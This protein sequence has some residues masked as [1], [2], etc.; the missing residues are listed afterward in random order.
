M[1]AVPVAIDKYVGIVDA[2]PYEGQIDPWTVLTREGDVTGTLEVRGLPFDA[3]P[4]RSLDAKNSVWATTLGEL[5]RS[6]KL[7]LWAHIVR[8]SIT[9]NPVTDDY[10]NHFS[11]EF[12]NQYARKY[13]NAPQFINRLYLSPV[14][15]LHGSALDRAAVRYS[16]TDKEVIAKRHLA[17]TESLQGAMRS[18]ASSLTPY[19][20]TIL[21]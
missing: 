2:L 12:A 14:V 4:N 6:T 20:P 8:Q 19:Q 21:E 10:D 9:V 3:M 16:R 17:A 13:G 1:S 11:R 5:F 7:A 18:L 15:R